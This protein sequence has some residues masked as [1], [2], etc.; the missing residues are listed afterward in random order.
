MHAVPATAAAMPAAVTHDDLSL[1]KAHERRAARSSGQAAVALVALSVI[2]GLV[3]FVL[4]LAAEGSRSEVSHYLMSVGGSR[5]QLDVCFYSGSGRAALAYAVGAF[6]LL[7]VAML[8]EHAYM[9]VAVA[10]PESA[11]AGLAVAQDNPRVA[12]TAATLTWQTCCLFF[13]TW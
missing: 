1:R 11:S 6:V 7:A 5:D 4:C 3:A 10:A 13:L 2:C 8:A 12:S 9:L